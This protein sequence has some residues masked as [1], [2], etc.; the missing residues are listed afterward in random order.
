M[1]VGAGGLGE[2]DDVIAR[3]KGRGCRSLISGRSRDQ[4]TS[5]Y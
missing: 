5:T 4:T 3:G 1:R 2:P